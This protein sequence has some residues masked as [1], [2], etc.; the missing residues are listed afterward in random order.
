MDLYAEE[1]AV[2]TAARLAM[3]SA[4]SSNVDCAHLDW[5]CSDCTANAAAAYCPDMEIAGSDKATT[6]STVSNLAVAHKAMSVTVDMGSFPIDKVSA[7]SDKATLDSIQPMNC[8]RNLEIL[9]VCIDQNTMV[10]SC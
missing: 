2:L 10:A 5:H 7:D 4:Y 3:S 6:H 8:N 9:A 1:R